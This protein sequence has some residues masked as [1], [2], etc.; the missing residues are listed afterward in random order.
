[1]TSPHTHLSVRF[2]YK[3]L[4]RHSKTLRDGFRSIISEG[5]RL[6]HVEMEVLERVLHSVHSPVPVV[7]S[8]EGDRLALE[9]VGELLTPKT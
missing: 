5:G 1:M 9:N 2:S 8:V 6:G 4:V 3:V 7:H